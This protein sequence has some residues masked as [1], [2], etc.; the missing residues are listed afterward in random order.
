MSGVSTSRLSSGGTVEVAV[1]GPPDPSTAG[2]PFALAHPGL[3][4]VGLSVDGEDGAVAAVTTMTEVV[5]ASSAVDHGVLRS[6]LEAGGDVTASSELMAV[7]VLEDTETCSPTRRPELET[8]CGVVGRPTATSVPG[9]DHGHTETEDVV[10]NMVEMVQ[11]GRAWAGRLQ[12][13][14]QGAGRV[15]RFQRQLRDR[16][17]A[18][19]CQTLDGVKLAPAGISAAL[20][21]EDARR[22]QV[23][24]PWLR[25]ELR[26]YLKEQIGARVPP[27]F[28][29]VIHVVG[30]AQANRLETWMEGEP[31][32]DAPRRAAAAGEE[33]V[34]AGPPSGVGAYPSEIDQ[35]QELTEPRRDQPRSADATEDTWV[36]EQDGE[37]T[38]VDPVAA[39]QST[40][41]RA[42]LCK[43]RQVGSSGQAWSVPGP[44][45]E[46]GRSRDADVVIEDHAVSREHLRVQATDLGPVVVLHERTAN[47]LHV[48]G[49]RVSPGTP[50]LLRRGTRLRLSRSC[51]LEVDLE[52]RP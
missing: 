26:T 27:S 18:D 10:V 52:T 21:A 25:R 50:V 28:D 9:G 14:G 48:D 16:L 33:T 5:L 8:G 19:V 46:V 12:G 29:V 20:T 51:E 34:P 3:V 47:G 44:V 22:V 17:A 45:A 4:C 1:S 11:V 23:V 38:W 35:A 30:A 6:A 31:R 24:L 42:P 7:A 41:M 15:V 49:E 40:G 37:E 32:P 2:T 13:R 43:L 36:E 39:D